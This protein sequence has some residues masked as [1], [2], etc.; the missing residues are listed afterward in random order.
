[1]GL[2]DGLFGLSGSKRS[3]ENPNTPITDTTLDEG[4][5][6]PDAI[7]I[8]A[9]TILSIPEFYRAVQI[10]S[11]VIASLPFS[12]VRIEDDRQEKL[13]THPVTRLINI[14]PSEL[15]TSYS[16]LETLVLHLEL[17]GNFYAEIR[18]RQTGEIRS[19]EILDPASI[20]I[21]KT[22][23][24]DIRYVEHRYAKRRRKKS[25]KP[26]LPHLAASELPGKI[27]EAA[28]ISPCRDRQ[29]VHAAVGN[30]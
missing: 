27:V 9:N 16:F 12:V 29:R 19:L 30:L 28:S 20:K 24:G 7:R 25:A 13:L 17:Y 4:G 26:G 8:D 3:L 5:Q 15:Y 18:R 10:K 6:D 23:R 1:M 11:G 22:D 14:R 21:E 2:F